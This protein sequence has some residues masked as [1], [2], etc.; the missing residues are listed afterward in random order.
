MVKS[1]WG[2]VDDK[3]PSTVGA[4]LMTRKIGGTAHSLKQEVTQ[5]PA[6]WL[7]MMM[8]VTVRLMSYY[9]IIIIMTVMDMGMDMGKKLEGR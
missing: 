1:V 2:L 4:I 6:H 9:T 8:K 3:Y 7:M 5:M